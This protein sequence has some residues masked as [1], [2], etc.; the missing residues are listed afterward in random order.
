S[1][2]QEMTE[3]VQES[4]TMELGKD[5]EAELKEAA[6]KIQA[7]FKGYKARKDLRPVFKE[8]FKEQTKEPNASSHPDSV[9]LAS[10]AAELQEQLNV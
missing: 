9:F 4:E 7:A 2:C 3:Q 6:V 1:D 5:D 10:D 8:V